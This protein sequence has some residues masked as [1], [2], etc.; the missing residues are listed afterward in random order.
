MRR[1]QTDDRVLWDIIQGI[2][3]YAAVFVAHDLHLFALLA[4]RPCTLADVC[5]ALQIA[6]R[7]AE[8]LLAVCAS[9]G[10]VQV[11]AGRYRLTPVSEAYLVPSSPTFFGGLL[12][13]V[14]AT[15]AT[16][17]FDSV[18]H[19]VRTNAPQAYGGGE[20]PTSPQEH[21]AR[22][23]AFAHGMHARGMAPALIWPDVLDLAHSRVMLDVGGGSGVYSITA[24]QRWPHLQAIVLDQA[25]VCEVA[26]E[27]I[28]QYG[29]QQRIRTQVGDMWQDPFPAADLHFYSG[30]YH[31]W[32]PEKCRLL[33]QKSFASLAAGGRLIIHELLYNDDKTGPFTVA[34]FAVTMLMISEGQQF[35][36]HELSTMLAEAGFTEIEV[37]PTFGYWS[38]VTGRKP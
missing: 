17:S 9:L 28:A 29:L 37:K 8:A 21:A 20:V 25:S 23:R 2:S 5:A 10:L 32:P 4:E 34:S 22:M 36:G 12:D 33:T 27:Y 30:V 7:P 26:Q 31:D 35:S 1:P 3:G 19:T 6:Q 15:Y 18:K 13:M 24:A 11:H 16:Y 14:I 38:M